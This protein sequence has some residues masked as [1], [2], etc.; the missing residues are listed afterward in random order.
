MTLTPGH[1]VVPLGNPD[2]QV[3]VRA[4]VLNNVEGNSAGTADVEGAAGLDCRAPIGILSVL[5]CRRAR[6][7]TRFTVTIPALENREYPIE[8]I[9][10]TEAGVFREG[11]DI[12]QHR[13]L[14]TRYLYRDAAAGVRG[15]DVKIPQ[16]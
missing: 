13:D 7:S 1:V 11:Y 6:R 3:R 14:E 12:I 4:E 16:G 9:A 8:A 2:K 15:V 5:P 10:T